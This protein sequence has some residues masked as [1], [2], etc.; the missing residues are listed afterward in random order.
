MPEVTEA[1]R[2]LWGQPPFTERFRYPSWGP[3]RW[4]QPAVLPGVQASG[5]L[6][7]LAESMCQED[8]AKLK[9]SAPSAPQLCMRPFFVVNMKNG[10]HGDVHGA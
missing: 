6:D 10:Q 8:W 4:W 7:Q 9:F 5:R 3:T 1:P 2:G